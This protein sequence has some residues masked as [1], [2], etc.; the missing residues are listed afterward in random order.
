MDCSRIIK[1]VIEKNLSVCKRSIYVCREDSNK[2][3]QVALV[4]I[5]PHHKIHSLIKALKCVN[6]RSTLEWYALTPSI[7]WLNFK[8]ECNEGS[9]EKYATYFVIIKYPWENV[10]NDLSLDCFVFVGFSTYLG[11][12]LYANV[13]RFHQ[14]HLFCHSFWYMPV[15]C[16][17]Y[18]LIKVFMLLPEM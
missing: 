10:C 15:T 3:I 9:L 5:N 12:E 13:R 14:W 2:K 8:T 1:I 4:E 16:E 18:L 17:L 11:G 6:V 7:F